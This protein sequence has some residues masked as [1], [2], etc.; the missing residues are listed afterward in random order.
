[1]CAVLGG[2]QIIF[3]KIK[4]S[5]SLSQIVKRRIN[6]HIRENKLVANS[7]LPSENKLAELFGVSRIT[8]H[9]AYTQLKQDGII[10]QIQGKGTFLK[11]NPMELKSGLEVLQGVTE[12]IRH[13]HY[14]PSTEY[15]GVKIDY[16]SE[17]MQKKLHI[18]EDEHVVT[19]YRKR[20]ANNEFAVYSVS[21]VPL[22]YFKGKAPKEFPGESMLSYF[23]KSLGYS[24]ESSLSE[25]T[26]VMADKEMMKKA[27][28]SEKIL[29]ILLKQLIFDSFGIPIIYSLD[30]FNSDIF[31]FTI[32][33][34]R[35]DMS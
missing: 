31:K 26:P 4:S 8:V 12:I 5:E 11:R 10:Y 20:Y 32:V 21:S 34:M 18:E 2:E 7:K 13:F 29:F 24:F 6:E 28:I 16:P 33:R 14:E 23:E 15:L 25:I 9:E 19:Y 30:Y 22:K 3:E 1:M 35:N 17:E 27:N